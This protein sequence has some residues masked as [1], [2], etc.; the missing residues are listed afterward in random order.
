MFVVCLVVVC[1]M[2]VLIRILPMPVCGTTNTVC[3]GGQHIMLSDVCIQNTVTMAT[4]D[5]ELARQDLDDPNWIVLVTVNTGYLDF[6]QNWFRYFRNLKLIVP[7][8]VIAEDNKCF[9]KLQQLFS[10]TSYSLTIERSSSDNTESVANFDSAHFNKLVG[11]RPTHILKYLQLGKNVLYSD[12]DSVWLRNPFPHFVGEFDIWAQLD[13]VYHCTGFLAIKTNQ[14]TLQF[15]REWKTY[16]LEKRNSINDQIGFLEMDKSRVC[17]QGLNTN[18]FPAGYQYFD[19]TN[20]TGYPNAK[21][22]NAVVVHNNYIVGHDKKIERF[23]KFNLW[24]N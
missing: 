19:E 2:L 18:F 1:V 17:I 15:I 5:V 24:M 7:V 11:E 3:D 23:Q 9:E 4:Q 10:N 21:Y 13:N 12:T 22:A 14:R 8:I 20:Y 6:F 16:I